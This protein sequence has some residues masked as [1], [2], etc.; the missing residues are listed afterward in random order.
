MVLSTTL[1]APFR[2]TPRSTL[3]PARCWA[4]RVLSYQHRVCGLELT[5]LA[6]VKGGQAEFSTRTAGRNRSAMRFPALTLPRSLLNML[7]L[8]SGSAKQRKVDE[9]SPDANGNPRG[10]E[11]D[12]STRPLQGSELIFSQ[13]NPV[14][15]NLCRQSPRGLLK[16]SNSLRS[17]IERTPSGGN[18][19]P[20]FTQ[21]VRNSHPQAGCSTANWTLL[22]QSWHPPGSLKPVFAGSTEPR[23]FSG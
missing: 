2:S 8:V 6:G 13:D 7:P 5:M 20:S 18:E 21:L 19:Y 16:R 23:P 4:N 12:G 22:L 11:Q 17:Q 9:S 15:D 3:K 14:W 10:G 1:T